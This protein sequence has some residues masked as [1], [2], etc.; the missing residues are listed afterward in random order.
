[1]NKATGQ[2]AVMS[3]GLL[4]IL[5]NEDFGLYYRKMVNHAYRAKDLK[6]MNPNWGP[7]IS[8][9]RHEDLDMYNPETIWNVDGKP[10]DFEYSHEVE[11]N[12]KHFWLSVV[13]EDALR[14]RELLG[15]PRQPH[16][17]LHITIGIITQDSTR[18]EYEDKG[19]L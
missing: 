6:I 19:V 9:T 8:V 16:F 2:Y 13:C 14:I 15:L 4:V 10:V 17:P 3:D 5:L 18:I 7:H 11:S 1:M 12:G